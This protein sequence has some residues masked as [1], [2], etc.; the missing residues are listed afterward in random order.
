MTLAITL[1]WPPRVLSPNARSHW[2]P[3]AKAAK[4]YRHTAWA[5]TRAALDGSTVGAMAF[6]IEYTF[7][8]P[9]HRPFDL[10]NALAWMKSGTDGIAQALCLNDKHFTFAALRGEVIRGGAVRVRIM[11]VLED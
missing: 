6:H 4:L 3:K 2:A 10:D 7:C 5:L 1:P 8:A 9:S 11:P